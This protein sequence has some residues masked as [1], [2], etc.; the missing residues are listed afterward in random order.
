[1]NFL[2][3]MLRLPRQA[4]KGT[5]FQR[6][7]ILIFA[8]R[9]LMFFSTGLRKDYQV[10]FRGMLLN[11]EGGDITILPTLIDGTFEEKEIDWFLERIR[12]DK[13]QVLFIDI[14]ANIGIYSLLALENKTG[15]SVVSVEPDNRNLERLK[16]N[17]APYLG[18]SQISLFECAIG[19]TDSDASGSDKRKF[20]LDQYGGTSRLTNL[21]E[22]LG[23]IN[24]T[25][26]NVISL[27]YLMREVKFD[28]F[29]D[30]I[31]KIDVEGF[32]PEVV[33]SG[34]VSILQS[35]PTILIEYTNSPERLRLSSW[36]DELL[37]MLF[38]KYSTVLAISSVG[39]KYLNNP[40]NLKEFSEHEVLN[41][42]FE[43]KE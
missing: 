33:K 36:D 9:L 32:E 2:M 42:V 40:S 27:D 7:V 37:S 10:N 26:V 5:R 20:L 34:L 13:G 30:V 24:L 25:Q 28:E 41:L 38:Q 18:S 11:A 29:D 17:L 23:S 4:I 21:N 1:M 8:Y 22:D 39:V 31:I 16:K 6:N 19:L 12:E 3:R 15:V 35:L 14:G 43:Y